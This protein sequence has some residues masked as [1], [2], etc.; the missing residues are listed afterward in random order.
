LHGPGALQARG[1][2]ASSLSLLHVIRALTD[3]GLPAHL[4]HLSLNFCFFISSLLIIASQKTLVAA[5]VDFGF[6]FSSLSRSTDREEN[7]MQVRNEKN[8]AASGEALRTLSWNTLFTISRTHSVGSATRVSNPIVGG[9][10]RIDC[11]A[12]ALS[13]RICACTR[14]NQQLPFLA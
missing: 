11:A 1:F 2:H 13:S 6:C 4:F 10:S 14:K 3:P 7:Q 8:R 12:S 9:G 5:G